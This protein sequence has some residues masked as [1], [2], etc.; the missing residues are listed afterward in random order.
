MICRRYVRYYPEQFADMERLLRD[1]ALAKDAV[2]EFEQAVA[3]SCRR[4]HAVAVAS[5][6]QGMAYLFAALDLKPGDEIIFPAYTLKDLVILAQQ[7]GY[8]PVLADIDR[9]TLNMAPAQLAA[10]LTPRTRAVVA[11]HMFGVPCPV[12]EISELTRPRGIKVI[13]DC[14]HA[15]GAAVAGR[16][17]GSFGDAAF[18]SFELTKTVNTFGGGVM[19]T[20][21]D[22][23]ARALRTRVAQLPLAPAR[24]A[25][26]V[27][28]AAREQVLLG[29][30][31]FGWSAWLFYFNWT[32]R[33]V[34]RAYR[35]AQSRGRLQDVQYHSAQAYVGL[36]QLAALPERER[37]RARAAEQLRQLC[38]VEMCWQQPVPETRVNNY[39]AVPRFPGL[40]AARARQLFL[41]HGVDVGVGEEIVDDCRM[42]VPGPPCP[43]AQAAFRE[44]VQLP[45][46]EELTEVQLA[47]IAAAC[48]AVV[49]TARL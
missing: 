2:A 33:W 19:V 48:R 28:A 25:H 36:R 30:R 45:L 3:Q 7:C 16:P 27:R 41:R 37:R 40:S 32:T 1:S 12:R 43:A 17:V 49:G 47:H 10:V 31:L 21:D 24:V 38:P 11:T 9:A 18:F 22:A 4:R 5:G 34:N 46:H 14:A 8:R 44:A 26:K 29:S 13:E 15:F 39:F 35:A 42:V 6:R 23:V 20:D